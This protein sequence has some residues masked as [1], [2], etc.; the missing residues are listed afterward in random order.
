MM[1]RPSTLEH[2]DRT[3]LHVA[4]LLLAH[5]KENRVAEFTTLQGIAKAGVADADHLFVPALDILFL[6]GLVEYQLKT[7]TFVFPGRP[8]APPPRP[9][10][11]HAT[12]V[13]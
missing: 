10:G 3:V 11:G 5:I 7:D 8:H 12:A 1:L 13:H 6:L 2:P 9:E 4:M